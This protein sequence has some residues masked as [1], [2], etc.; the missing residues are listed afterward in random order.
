MADKIVK[1]KTEKV[2]KALASIFSKMDKDVKKRQWTSAAY[3]ATIRA[4]AEAHGA[5]W[6]KDETKDANGKVNGGSRFEFTQAMRDS[7][8][9][10]SSNLKK[11]AIDRGW[12]PAVD[13]YSDVDFDK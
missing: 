5:T 4:V 9:S 2:E 10:F 3:A 6:P 1:P 13:Q 8:L 12:L 11:Y 7:D